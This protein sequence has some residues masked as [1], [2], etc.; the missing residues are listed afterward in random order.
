MSA[1]NLLGIYPMQ[2]EQ[3]ASVI[4][5][6]CDKYELDDDELWR[7]I[8]TDMDERFGT[9]FSSLSNVITAIL[10]DNLAA[11]LEESGVEKKRIGF[12]INGGLDTHFYI[13]GE[14]V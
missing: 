1:L 11:S 12:Y 4:A 13:D 5:D 7:Q 9:E 6:V 10:F 2:L 3:A 14:E 8:W